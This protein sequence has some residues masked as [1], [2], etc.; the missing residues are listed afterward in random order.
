VLPALMLNY[1]GQGALLL[2]HPEAIENPFFHLAPDWAGVPMVL[3][4][5]TA[6]VIASQAVI[7]GA[8]SVTRQAMYLGYLPRMSIVHTSETEIGQIYIPVLNWTL[9]IFVVALVVGFQTSTNLASA[10]GVAVT[11]TMVIDTVLIALVMFLLWKWPPHLTVP[12]IA[13]FLIVDL[14]FFL[15]NSTKILHGGWFPLTIGLVIFL[16]L[17]TWNRGRALLKTGFQRNAIPEEEFFRKVSEEAV[18]VPGTAIFLANATGVPLSLLNNLK[19]NHILHERVI[20]L[21]VIIEEEPYVPYD[22]RVEGIDL[23]CNCYRVNLHYGYMQSPNIPQT[24]ANA[25]YNQLGFIYEPATVSY[26]LSRKTVI[27]SSKPGMPIWREKLFAWMFRSS[28]NPLEFF[29]LPFD[30]VV[31]LGGQVEI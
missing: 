20:L 10:Y 1:F 27:P 18:R 17:T 3:L 2:T 13:F 12:L 9:A 7:S 23:S 30:R 5:T 16:L 26:F 25:R 6:S 28:A 22:H 19:H 21:S 15:A 31:E 4:A 8:F 29:C 14:A 24:L 11:G